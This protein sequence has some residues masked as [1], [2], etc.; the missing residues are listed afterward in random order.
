VISEDHQAME[1]REKR[2][3]TIRKIE[4]SRVSASFSC[5]VYCTCTVR[6]Y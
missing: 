3:K 4:G 2:M 6:V 1:K 5:T